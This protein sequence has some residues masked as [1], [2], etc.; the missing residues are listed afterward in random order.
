VEFWRRDTVPRILCQISDSA[1]ARTVLDLAMRY[2][3]AHAKMR[4]RCDFLLERLPKLGS[5]VQ[6]AADLA[7]LRENAKV[8]GGGTKKDW[9]SEDVYNQFRDAAKALRDAIDEVE[10]RLQFDPATALPAAALALQLLSLTADVAQHY[11]Q[12]KRELG[13]LD[14]DDLL[15]RARQLLVGP[16]R[17]G[18]RKRLAAQ[19]RLL[20]VDEFQDTDARQ[21]E[22]LK[23]LCDNEHLHG[24]L[25]FV[26]DYKQ[27]I[28]RFRGAEPHV[29]RQLR[30]E[31]PEAGQMSLTENFR[32]QPAVLAFV[33]ELFSEELGPS[34]EPLRAHR[35]QV[36]PTPAVEFLW[37]CDTAPL[38]PGEGPGAGEGPQPQ[39]LTLTLSQRER[40]L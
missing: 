24:K 8:Q 18:L 14:F 40:G 26:G 13:M 20:L 2:P 37:A 10:S 6:P 7:A 28:Y 38:A 25:F 27:S 31:V 11:E 19:I 12:R 33:N 15:I 17:A 21:V 4:E 5:S 29:F 16:E 30:G 9:V 23:S 1:A 32:S 35:P 22:M 3:P 39:A 36:G 34:Y